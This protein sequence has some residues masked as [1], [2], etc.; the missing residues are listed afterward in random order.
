MN[1]AQQT[2]IARLRRFIEQQEIER[3]PANYGA[4]ITRWDVQPTDYGTLWV[5]AETELTGLPAGN[6]LRALDHT[7][8]FVSIGKR[9]A[10]TMKI[11]PKSLD[12]FEGRQFLGININYR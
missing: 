8:Y 11:G 7:H 4:Q 10:L 9:G 1:K 2:A 5:T 6:L 3:R 12:Q